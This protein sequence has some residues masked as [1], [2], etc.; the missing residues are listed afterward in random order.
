MVVFP[1]GTRTADGSIGRLRPGVLSMAVRAHVPIV[2]AAIDGA[3]EAWPRGRAPW[4]HPIAVRYG[5]A[6]SPD[7][8]EAMTRV[9]LAARLRADLLAL[10]SALR[11]RAVHAAGGS[12]VR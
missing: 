9:E 12:A 3:F 11:R 7:E 5:R 6:I 2:P 10:Q 1:E 4:F 8:C